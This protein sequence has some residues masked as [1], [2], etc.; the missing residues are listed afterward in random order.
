MATSTF[1][2]FEGFEG[3]FPPV[4]WDMKN[5]AGNSAFVWKQHDAAQY[6]YEGN[7]AAY[8]T[9]KSSG[10]KAILVTPEFVFENNK[11]YRIEFFAFRGTSGASYGG[12]GFGVYLSETPNITENSKLLTFIPRLTNETSEQ[13]IL[14]VSAV[15]AQGMYQ[16]KVDFNTAQ[17]SGKYVI[18][19][20]ITNNGYYQSFDNLWI[21]EKPAIDIIAKFSVD[22][23]VIDAARINIPDE[24]IAMFD[25]V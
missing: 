14:P 22:S 12:E 10:S 24:T 4:C 7:Y 21:G 11:D 17:Y 2:F 16:Y 5:T 9:Y 25:L 18:F 20:A 19:E 3:S 6:V 1:P 15:S 23:V 8:W 13:G